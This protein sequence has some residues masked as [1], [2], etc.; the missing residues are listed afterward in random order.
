[1]S[2]TYE[3]SSS[4]KLDSLK[5]FSICKN[6]PNCVSRR[7]DGRGQRWIAIL[8]QREH[9]EQQKVKTLSQIGQGIFAFAAVERTKSIE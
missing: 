9:F 7:R 4:L 6:A 5:L 2:G 8:Q 3:T 1:M